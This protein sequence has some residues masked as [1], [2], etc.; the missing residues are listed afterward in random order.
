LVLAARTVRWCLSAF[1]ALQL[2]ASAPQP[3]TF[4]MRYPPDLNITPRCSVV[5]RVFGSLITIIL[6]ALCVYS[7]RAAGQ[8]DLKNALLTAICLTAAAWLLWDAW[9][10]PQGQL[11]FSQGQWVLRRGDEE[12]RGTLQWHLDL[13]NYMLLSFAPTAPGLMH[14]APWHPLKTQWFH[15]EAR[16]ANRDLG[17]QSWQAWR[18]AVHACMTPNHEERKA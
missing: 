15:L 17:L 7:I 4:A 1:N 16:Q 10:E 6:I 9:R 18:R 12:L 11:F 13:Q 3:I 2:T 5:Y 14:Q 8:F